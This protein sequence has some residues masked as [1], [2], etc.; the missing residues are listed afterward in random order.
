MATLLVRT[1]DLLH[2]LEQLHAWKVSVIAQTRL[3]F[4]L[5][6][7]QGKMLAADPDSNR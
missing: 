4:D 6:T 3:Q 7:P 1:L 2:T 5:A